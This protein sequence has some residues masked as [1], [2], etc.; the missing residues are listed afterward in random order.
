MV[1]GPLH[2]PTATWGGH[3]GQFLLSVLILSSSTPLGNMASR[4]AELNSNLLVQDK[5]H[6]PFSCALL[7]YD[8]PNAV[9]MPSETS[10]TS[11][12]AGFSIG[13]ATNNSVP[14]ILA[15]GRTNETI[16]TGPETLS[17]PC[18]RHGAH[19]G[20]TLPRQG[21]TMRLLCDPSLARFGEHVSPRVLAPASNEPANHGAFDLDSK[22]SDV[23][24]EL[25]S[26]VDVCGAG[27]GMNICLRTSPKQSHGCR[28][29]YQ[30]C[31]SCTVRV[32]DGPHSPIR[33]VWSGMPF[34]MSVA[35]NPARRGYLRA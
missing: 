27:G 23:E 10:N 1:A 22:T 32:A 9:P 19:E 16:C 24:A 15:A 7:A 31:C 21:H 11:F 2:L 26:R 28:S 30:G 20:S 34:Y 14:P 33:R 25:G 17:S 35:D 3:M 4:S 8:G 5:L 29:A 13:T 18:G 6:K 12:L